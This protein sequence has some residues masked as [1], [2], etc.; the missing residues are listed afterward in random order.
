M[1]QPQTVTCGM[2]PRWRDSPA[3]ARDGVPLWA[4]AGLVAAPPGA[5]CC[6]PGSIAVPN[7]RRTAQNAVGRV[8]RIA[9]DGWPLP[10]VGK[11]R[12]WQRMTA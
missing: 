9:L 2:D 11:D 6:L 10:R 7:A 4:G 8:A 1:A 5:A 3:R 12:G